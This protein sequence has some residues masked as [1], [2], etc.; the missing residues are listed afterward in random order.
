MIGFSYK[1]N[2]KNRHFMIILDYSAIFMAYFEFVVRKKHQ[3]VL[4]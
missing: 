4:F 2:T 3:D 1:M